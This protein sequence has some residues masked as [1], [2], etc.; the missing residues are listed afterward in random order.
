MSCFIFEKIGDIPGIYSFAL[1]FYRDKAVC[2]TEGVSL[3]ALGGQEIIS[4]KNSH[5]IPSFDL[6][7]YMNGNCYLY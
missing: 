5:E 3:G 6:V 7:A 4:N 2:L 1:L